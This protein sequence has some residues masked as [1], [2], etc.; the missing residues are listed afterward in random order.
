MTL[1]N[2]S[3]YKR[4]KTLEDDAF[5]ETATGGISILTNPDKPLKMGCVQLDTKTNTRPLWQYESHVTFE[6]TAF[7]NNVGLIAGGLHLSNGFTKFQKCTF[8]DKQSGHIYSAYGPGRVEFENC[9][10]LRAKENVSYKK[11]TFLYSESGG[12]LKLTNISM[13][14][15]V[16]EK[17]SFPVLATSS[18]GYVDIDEK[19]EIHCSEGSKL[20][21]DNATHIFYTNKNNMSLFYFLVTL[22]VIPTAFPEFL[23]FWLCS[24]HTG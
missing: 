21:L 12:P 16:L 1:Y 11:S 18:G 7:E 9:S 23:H 8:Q 13:V 3:F 2:S 5:Y 24:W 4:V 19:S 14:S 22:Y 10:F 15:L 6:D 20:L 17:N